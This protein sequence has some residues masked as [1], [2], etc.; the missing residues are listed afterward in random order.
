M[1]PSSAPVLAAFMTGELQGLIALYK[2]SV[3]LDG[4]T[5]KAR[6]TQQVECTNGRGEFA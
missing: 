5:R 2:T 3:G 4:G 6:D 1:T